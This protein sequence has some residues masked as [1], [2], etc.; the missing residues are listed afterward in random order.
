MNLLRFMTVLM[1]YIEIVCALVILIQGGVYN[2]KG[3]NEIIVVGLVGLVVTNFI[4]GFRYY[5]TVY[6]KLMLK[7]KKFI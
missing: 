5:R 4:F 2:P 6:R 7:R 3:V 1:G